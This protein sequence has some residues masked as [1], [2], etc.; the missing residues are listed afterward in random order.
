MVALDSMAGPRL[1][2]SPFRQR[3]SGVGG[4]AIGF[5]TGLSAGQPAGLVL[6]QGRTGLGAWIGGIIGIVGGF[7]TGFIAADA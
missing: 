6:L 1:I 2:D 4:A 3:L 7:I 5:L